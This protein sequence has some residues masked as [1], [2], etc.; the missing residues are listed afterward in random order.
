[1]RLEFYWDD[2]NN[3]DGFSNNL[4]VVFTKSYLTCSDNLGSVLS[5][6]TTSFRFVAIRSWDH[7]IR[8][9]YH[10][11]DVSPKIHRVVHNAS[12]IYLI[13]YALYLGQY[14]VVVVHNPT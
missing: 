7:A 13:P 5:Y 9:N 11:L 3:H 4:G 10:S 2:D 12:Q 1:M 6:T 14:Q 8:L